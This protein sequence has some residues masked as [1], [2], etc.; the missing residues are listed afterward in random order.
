ME[1]NDLHQILAELETNL[2]DLN[3]ARE[4]VVT[5]AQKS[6]KV[7]N[8]TKELI[9]KLESFIQIVSNNTFDFA[10]GFSQSLTSFKAELES[11]INSSKEKT[12]KENKRIRELTSSFIKAINDNFDDF[13][14]KSKQTFNS[15]NNELKNI[16]SSFE[17]ST[18]EQI[19]IVNDVASSAKN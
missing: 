12:D 17:K 11:F 14:N 7:N 2:K 9:E 15:F 1:I 18:N 13:N 4:Q 19:S 16:S 8:S 3:S 10:D 6:D 5:V